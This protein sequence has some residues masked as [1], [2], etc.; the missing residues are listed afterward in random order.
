MSQY[1]P[2]VPPQLDED[3]LPYLNDEFLRVALAMNNVL[4]GL[5]EINHRL[6]LRL[7]PGLVVYLAGK[8]KDPLDPNDTG[9]DPLGTGEE[10]LYRY[11]TTGWKYI[12]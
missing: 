6:P 5:W 1:N 2:S 12:G 9:S 4:A 11:G 10:G 3:L 8:P 7:K